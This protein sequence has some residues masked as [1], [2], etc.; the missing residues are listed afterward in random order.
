MASGYKKVDPQIKAEIIDKAKNG[1]K[2]VDLAKQYGFFYRTIYKW[3]GQSANQTNDQLEI[4]R[5]KR[6]NDELLK[7][8]GE[9][10]LEIQKLKKNINKV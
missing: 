5:L 2:V 10:T 7:I 9:Q 8:I 3:L 1:E 6:Q 4:S